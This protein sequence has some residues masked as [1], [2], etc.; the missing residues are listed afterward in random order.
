VFAAL[1]T[2]YVACGH[3]LL[4]FNRSLSQIAIA[5]VAC[6]LL[7]FAYTKVASGRSI[8]PLS[9]YITGL[10]LAILFTAPGNGWLMLLASWLAISSKYLITAGGRHVFNPSN[11]AMVALL[12]GSGGHVAV[13]PAYQW[14]TSFWVLGLLVAAGCVVVWRARRWPTVLGFVVAYVVT[15]LVRVRYT[16]TPMS[17]T[18]WSQVTGGAFWLFCFSM[19]T[20]PRTSP[21]GRKEQF[22]FGSA[23]G[24]LDFWFQVAF[25][26][27]SYF[28][29]LFSACLLRAAGGAALS[30]WVSRRRRNPLSGPVAGDQP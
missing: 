9:G 10:G 23:I 11:F 16:G 1:H 14:G 19:I 17:I 21:E 28:Y 30:W 7:D 6:S 15:A 27:F 20:D 2:S 13:A 4:D 24:F 5:I 8:V 22:A 25:V 29:A 26:V 18:L 12:A 3:L